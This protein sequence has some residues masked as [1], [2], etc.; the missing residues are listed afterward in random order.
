MSLTRGVWEMACKAG[1]SGVRALAG[2]R[3]SELG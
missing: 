2:V 3:S 1:Y